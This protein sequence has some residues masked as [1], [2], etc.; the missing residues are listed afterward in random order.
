VSTAIDS[1]YGENMSIHQF[2]A[3]RKS[4]PL[5]IIQVIAAITIALMICPVFAN[6]IKKP[7]ILPVNVDFMAFYCGAKVAVAHQDP[8][9]LTPI[10]SCED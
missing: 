3:S 9:A 10:R 2:M 1:R 6:I 5:S 4:V 8:Y 7:T